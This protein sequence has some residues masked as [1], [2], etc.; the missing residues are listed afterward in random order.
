[1]D[2][3][4]ASRNTGKFGGLGIE[5]TMEDGYVKIVSPLDGTPGY[6][7]GLKAGDLIT[8]IDGNN[9][10]GLTLDEAVD[11][12]RGSV[13]TNVKLKIRREGDKKALEFTIT[14]AV[15]KLTAVKGC[16]LY[17]SNIGYLR[18][19]TFNGQTTSGLVKNIERIKKNKELKGFILDLR[20]NPGGLLYQAIS[21]SDMFL[22]EGEIVSTRGRDPTDIE[23]YNARK[24]NTIIKEKPLAVLINNGSASASEIVAGALQHHK[25]AKIIGTKSF[26]K[27]SVQTIFALGK[28][29]GGM[30]LT[31]AR[32]YTPN[33]TSIQAKGIVPDIT[34][35]QEDNQLFNCQ[36]SGTLNP[37]SYENDIQLKRA[38]E[39][40]INPTDEEPLEKNVLIPKS[41]IKVSNLEDIDK[42]QDMMNTYQFRC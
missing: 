36:G 12:M 40:L 13:A 32:Y 2:A 18:V 7:A 9:V 14:R 30:K 16:Y 28:E 25:R 31:T 27:G 26:G 11:L 42:F 29:Y 6:N 19:T 38:V 39:E 21:V 24:D 4:D 34:I 41:K 35:E 20:N 1:L 3:L 8:H 23:S 10:L 17:E 37:M 22:F 33:G 5:L 15:I